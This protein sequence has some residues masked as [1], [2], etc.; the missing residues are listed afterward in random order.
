MEA[1]L[2]RNP[3]VDLYIS[4]FDPG[5]QLM[6][7]QLRTVIR[8]AAPEA[9]EI[10]SYQMPAFRYH[11]MLAHFAAYKNHIGFYPGP[12]GIEAFRNEL[13]IYKGARGSVQFPFDKPLPLE[14]ISQIVE[15]RLIQ[16]KEK[17]I[18]K[19]KNKNTRMRGSK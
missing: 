2:N 14:L 18:S 15:F 11:G 19:G 7:E 9:E 12:E 5:T 10:F 16:N 4:G 13:S 8:D 3:L 1:N 17:S 6:L